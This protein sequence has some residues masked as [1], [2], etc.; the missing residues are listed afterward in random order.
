MDLIKFKNDI[1]EELRL[2][3]SKKDETPILDRLQIHLNNLT[4]DYNLATMLNPKNMNSEL[5]LSMLYQIV[6]PAKSKNKFLLK[7][8]GNIIKGKTD[9]DKIQNLVN[10]IGIDNIQKL[11][12]YSKFLYKKDIGDVIGN[13][14]KTIGNNHSFDTTFG[15]VGASSKI[16]GF[17]KEIQDILKLNIEII[18]EKSFSYS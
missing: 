1:N 2:K 13:G 4:Q 15:G 8:N 5:Y 9:R 17:I 6:Y 16:K 3:K 18:Y 10:I 14:Y 7:Y 12:T 11:Q